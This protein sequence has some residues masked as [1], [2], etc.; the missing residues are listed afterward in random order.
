[1]CCRL[2]AEQRDELTLLIE[3]HSIPASQGRIAGYRIG[4]DRSGG[5]ATILQLLASQHAN[6]ANVPTTPAL[7][8]SNSGS[9]RSLNH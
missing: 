2:A 9:P 1:V 8:D 6:I 3:L 4:E 7:T 5:D